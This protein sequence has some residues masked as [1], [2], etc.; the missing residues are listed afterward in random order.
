MTR[1]RG[2]TDLREFLAVLEDRNKLVRV[3]REI[4]KDTEM[5][6]LVRWQ[7][8]GMS[9]KGRKAFLFENVVDTRGR[10]FRS[11]ALPEL[12]RVKRM[13]QVHHLLPRRRAQAH[14]ARIPL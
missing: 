1:K 6:P 7:F 3:T 4:N 12:R 9:E 10:R 5:H 13:R 11:P 14:R 8:R 2:Y